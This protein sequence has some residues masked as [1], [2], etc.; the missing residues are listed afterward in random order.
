MWTFL[1]AVK[2]K[3]KRV[4]KTVEHAYVGSVNLLYCISNLILHN[5]N[6]LGKTANG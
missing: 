2:E 3:G 4:F 5:R 1:R 6:R